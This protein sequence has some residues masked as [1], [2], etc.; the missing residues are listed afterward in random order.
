MTIT[1]VVEQAT[2][3]GEEPPPAPVTMTQQTTGPVSFSGLPTPAT[4]RVRVEAAGFAP[5]E[6]EQ[7]VG[8]GATNVLNTVRPA[9]ATGSITGTVRS[10]SG[11]PLGNVEVLVTSGDLERK[12]TTP[13]VGD[14]GTFIIDGL[15]TPRTYVL[16]FSLDGFSGQTI[17]L[18]LGA[19]EHRTGVDAM[20]VSGTGTIS[21]TVTDIDGQP[22]GGVKVTVTR[23]DFL[24]DT[25]TLTTSGPGAGVGSYT[26]T[27]LPTPGNF[28]VTFSL[29]GTSTR[30]GRSA[31][32]CRRPV[33]HLGRRC[34]RADA[35]IVGTVTGPAARSSAPPS[36]CRTGARAGR[37][38]RPRTPG[39]YM[40][41]G[42][43]P[44]SYTLSVSAPGAATRVVL[45]QVVA[46]D[47][48]VRDVAL[49]VAP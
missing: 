34:G 30:R 6:F 27:D 33:G 8:G 13:T 38:R 25:A 47:E 2:E 44:G 35:T 22:L 3:E 14:V 19:G 11:A 31:S 26:V 5:Q 10:S 9:A 48:L 15:P 41:T 1:Q 46:G 16:T 29:P 49:G 39:G 17:A 24:A 32:S 28:A 42:V 36:S 40:F 43:A 7:T 37:H 12:A 4:Y 20:L 18:D 45:V 21:G 23:G